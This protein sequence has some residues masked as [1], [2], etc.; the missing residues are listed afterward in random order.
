MYVKQNW[1][2]GACPTSCCITWGW[3]SMFL[4]TKAKHKYNYAEYG[5]YPAKWKAVNV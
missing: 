2:R 5:N 1:I 3:G 4:L